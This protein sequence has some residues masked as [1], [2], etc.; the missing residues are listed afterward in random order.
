MI[1][2]LRF[3][4]AIVLLLCAG[5]SASAQFKE[6]KAAPF[7]AVAARQKI[8]S[9]LANANPE[10][11]DETVATMSGWLTWYRDTLDAELIARWKSDD[12]A[13]VPLVMS[14]L[15]DSRVARE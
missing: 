5:A 9:L 14:P 1:D 7:S 3:S 6:I 10:N 8:H 15:A 13:N 11:R 4:G 2:F 12:R